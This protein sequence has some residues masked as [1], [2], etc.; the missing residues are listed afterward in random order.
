MMRVVA[1][2][3]GE[4]EIAAAGLTEKYY[5]TDPE[6]YRHF[7]EQFRRDFLSFQRTFHGTEGTGEGSPAQDCAGS[8]A[9]PAEEACLNAFQR[10][11]SPLF[12]SSG[13]LL[14]IPDRSCRFRRTAD[15]A[16]A[17]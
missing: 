14:S 9:I 2:P 10:S 15:H 11:L 8:A 17:F 3:P 13:R 7:V 5:R 6:A 12:L 16:G 1:I 4:E